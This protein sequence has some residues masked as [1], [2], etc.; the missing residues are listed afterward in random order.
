MKARLANKILLGSEK[1]KNRYWLNRVIK[2]AL[3]WKEDQRVAKAR[4]IYHHK[5]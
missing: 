5:K 3:G 2:A 4:R 1:K